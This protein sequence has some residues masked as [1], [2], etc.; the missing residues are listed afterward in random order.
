M[1]IGASPSR[2]VDDEE[3]SRR[4]VETT[5]NQLDDVEEALRHVVSKTQGFLSE[6]KDISAR[7]D[8]DFAELKAVFPDGE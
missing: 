7:F 3:E 1:D 5:L 6:A 8:R 2:V 4:L